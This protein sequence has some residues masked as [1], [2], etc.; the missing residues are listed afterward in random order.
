MPAAYKNGLLTEGADFAQNFFASQNGF[1][2]K[3]ER[4]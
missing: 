2:A 1:T 3:A 4:R